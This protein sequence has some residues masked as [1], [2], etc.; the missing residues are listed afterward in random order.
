M[1][2]AAESRPLA[3]TASGLLRVIRSAGGALLTQSGL[4]AELLRVEWQETRVRLLKM[5]VA[6]LL[7]FACLLCLMLASGAVLVA[8]CWSTPFRLPAIAVL[9]ALY[10]TGA[11]IGWRRFQV[12]FALSAE[13]FAA[14]RA[15]LSADLALLRSQL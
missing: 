2:A 15:E 9:F 13:G 10:A 6:S 4:H 7:G 3:P 14:T 8:A 11:V 1:S 12:Q 5:L